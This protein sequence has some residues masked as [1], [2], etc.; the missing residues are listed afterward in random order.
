LLKTHQRGARRANKLTLH[1]LAAV[2]QHERE[3]IA[4]RTKSA[5]QAAK[6]RGKVLG[7][8]AKERLAPRYKQEA[9]ARATEL[10]PLLRELLRLG[11]SARAIARELTVRKVATPKGGSWHAVTVQRLRQR[12]V[13]SVP[14]IS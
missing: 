11:L 10:E 6:Q 9:I 14:A 13:R 7:R 3:L 8:N 2:A 5:L 1:I 12:I 4:E